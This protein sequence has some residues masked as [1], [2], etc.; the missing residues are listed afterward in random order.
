MIV[1][2][3]QLAGLG[4][5]LGE[6][7]MPKLTRKVRFLNAQDPQVLA[8]SLDDLNAGGV[9][10]TLLEMSPVKFQ[11]TTQIRFLDWDISVPYGVS[12]LSAATGRSIVPALITREAGPRFRL[13]F[14]EALPAPS[15]DRA[16]IFENTQQL[17]D[18]LGRKVLE[19]LEQW[20][21]WLLLGSHMGIDLGTKTTQEVPALS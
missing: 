9:V 11:K 8:R 20:I 18:L 6:T 4:E 13:R 10:S 15:R 17:Y 3:P 14:C 16:S 7:F 1:G 2:A 5:R 21:G 19:F 12:Y